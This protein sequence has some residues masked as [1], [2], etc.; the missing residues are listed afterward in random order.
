MNQHNEPNTAYVD[1]KVLDEHDH[2]VGKITDVVYGTSNDRPGD[3]DADRTPTWLVVDPGVLRA[4]HYVPVSGS[5]RTEG[6]DVVVPWS[7][8]WIKSA[9]KASNEH[10]VT[11]ELLAELTE[12]YGSS[13]TG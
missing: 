1:H 8:E 7:S 3:D 2:E 11:E 5:Y 4:P 6:G 13:P 9:P 10:V 12:H